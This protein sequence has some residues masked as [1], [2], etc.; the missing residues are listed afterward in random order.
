MWV[1]IL[2][3]DGAA[4]VSFVEAGSIHRRLDV[5]AEIDDIGNKLRMSLSLV[6][7]R[8]NAEANSFVILLHHGRNDGVQRTLMSCKRVRLARLHVETAAAIMQYEAG[9]LRHQARAKAAC[10]RLN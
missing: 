2:K 3:T 4:G 6:E 9:V 1:A 7:A 5:H 8:H 10:I